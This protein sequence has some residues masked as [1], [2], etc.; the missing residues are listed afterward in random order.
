ME[1]LPKRTGQTQSLFPAIPYLC[2]DKYDEGPFL[3]YPHRSGL[4]DLKIEG[5][6]GINSFLNIP[7]QQFLAAVPRSELEPFLQNWLFFGLL[8]E[9][10]GDLYRHEDFI[11]TVLDG[12]TEKTIVTTADLLSR[13]EEWE[14][15]I[16]QDKDSLITVYEHIAKCLTLAHACLTIKYPDFDNDLKFHLAS[17][18]EILGFAAS[19]ACNVAWT[20][21]STRSLIPPHWDATVSEHFQKSVLLERSNCCPSQMQMLIENFGSPQALSFVASCLHEDVLQLHHAPCNGNICRAGH[22]VT[23]DQLTRHVSDSCGCEF[24]RVDEG[25]L[26]DCLKTGC[27][28][29]LRLKEK[30]NSDEMSVEVIASTN[31]TSYVAL[32]HV[33][34]DGLGNPTATAL[35]RCQLSRLKVLIDNVNFKYL[36]MSIA[37]DGPEDAPEMLLWCDTLCCPVVSKEAQSMALSLMYRTYDEATVVLVLDRSL[38][39]HRV[40]GMRD[41]EAGLRIAASRWMT[42]LWTLQEGALAARKNNLWFQFTKTALPAWTLYIHLHKLLKTDIRRRGVVKSVI[43]RFHTFSGLFDRQSNESRGTQMEYITRGLLY[44]SVT[45]PSDEPLII[46]TLLSLDPSRILASEPAERM[47]VLWRII[48]TSPSGINKNILFHK[49]P[50]IHERGLRWAPQSLLFVDSNFWAEKPDEH[51]KRGFL[52]THGNTMGLVVELAGFRI[53]IAKP[54]KGLPKHLAGF[55]SE[56]R[57]DV[58]RHRLLLKDYQGRWYMLTHGLSG[59]SDHPST[60]EEMYTVVSTL[61]RPWVLYRG[62]RSPGPESR[63]YRGL[64]VK[65]AKEQSQSN[66]VTCVE[67]KSQ[68]SFSLLTTELNQ[69]CQAAYCLAQELASSAAAR[70]LEDVLGTAPTD[71][72][73]PVY[74]EALQGVDLEFKRLSRSLS[75]IKAVV[76]IGNSADERGNSTMEEFMESMYRGLYIQIEE[77][78]LGNRKWCVD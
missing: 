60:L 36:N 18:A 43:R 31:S 59:T 25:L 57:N 68:V 1:H 15:K 51:E 77:Y 75:A 17:V 12:G 37:L 72:D 56:P 30:T 55:G 50:K 47:N 52:A 69:V 78:A 26:A 63:N 4:P 34:A 5:T 6:L 39:S 22:S 64:L 2:Q 65:E 48:C 70:R 21:N 19:K 46:A 3:D 28:P 13:L 61:S 58:R 73:D 53:S 14:A 32:S 71:L 29:L 9:V 35:P 54:A 23:S 16:T 76:A 41:D 44:R 38:I 66:E 74:Q 11:T 45:V 33:W 40:G 27:L 62:S 7:K 10:L 20:D 67:M 42:R 8:N 49:G 24:L